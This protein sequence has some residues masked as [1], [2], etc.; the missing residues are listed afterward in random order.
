MNKKEFY[1]GKE[2]VNLSEVRVDKIVVSNKIEG[3][4]ETSKV[5]IGYID[6]VSSS[7]EPLMYYFTTNEWLDKIL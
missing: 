1:E 6:D 2:A 5:F 7:V 3:N 4:N